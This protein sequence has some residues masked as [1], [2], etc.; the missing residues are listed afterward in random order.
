M[1]TELGHE[2]NYAVV[3]S[4]GV[5][6]L[7]KNQSHHKKTKHINIELHFIRLEVSKEVVDFE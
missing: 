7:S 4:Y 3:S 2:Q 1:V 6:F 5:L